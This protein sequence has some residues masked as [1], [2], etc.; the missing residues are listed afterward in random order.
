MSMGWIGNVPGGWNGQSPKSDR[1]HRVSLGGILSQIATVEFYPRPLQG[2][3]VRCNLGVDGY[4]DFQDYL[5]AF[6]C[7]LHRGRSRLRHKL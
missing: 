6:W 2:E 4:L 7:N 1:H 5:G 3:W